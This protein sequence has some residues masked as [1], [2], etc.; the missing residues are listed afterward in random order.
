MNN[1]PSLDKRVV[2]ISWKKLCLPDVLSVTLHK[3][4]G[5]CWDLRW[6]PKE[7]TYSPRAAASRT[8]GIFLHCPSLSVLSFLMPHC[9]FSIPHCHFG[10]D[11]TP[12]E[13][14]GESPTAFESC[15][16]WS[17][18][19]LA[20]PVPRSLLWPLN[21]LDYVCAS[22]SF[23][24][25]YFSKSLSRAVMGKT[26][27][28]R[29]FFIQQVERKPVI[30]FQFRILL[31]NVSPSFFLTEPKRKQN[32][33]LKLKK[34]NKKNQLIMLELYWNVLLEIFFLI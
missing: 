25:L 11:S 12:A 16:L 19:P 30:F 17:F 14:S 8:D 5:G 2:S 34:K 15:F 33:S 4:R 7:Y 21:G 18:L 6:Q 3:V 26:V 27:W 31:N 13:V 22:F 29:W 23:Y 20:M 10:L 28:N 32:R 9:S 24:F 1:F